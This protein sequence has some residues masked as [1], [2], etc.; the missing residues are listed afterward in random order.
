MGAARPAL[1][2]LATACIWGYAWVQFKIALRYT[3]PLDFAALRALL[4]TVALFGVLIARRGAWQVPIP[5]FTIPAGMAQTGGFGI[6]TMLALQFGGVGRSSI[7]AYTFPLWVALLAWVL[8]RERL[9]RLQAIAFPI[10]AGGFAAIVYPFDLSSGSVSAAC[11]VGAGISWALG[12]VLTKV[13]ARQQRFDAFAMTAW[14]LLFGT[15]LVCAVALP[16]PHRPIVWDGTFIFALL[17]CSVISNGLGWFLWVY[18][19]RGLTAGVASF[20]ILLSPL[21]GATAAVV[22][23]H[24]HEPLPQIAGFAL[25]FVA[26]VIFSFQGVNKHATAG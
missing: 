5:R 4:A 1:A 25:I 21:I 6:L 17:F 3:T 24:E 9:G 7:L 15:I 12:A 26:L 13:A 16:F 11:A 19:L 18:A 2:L 10:A 20:G 14:Q 22:Q 23:L 8:L